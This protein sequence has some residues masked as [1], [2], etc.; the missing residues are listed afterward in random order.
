MPETESVASLPA[1]LQLS[2]DEQAF[3][4]CEAALV[5]DGDQ[6]IVGANAAA[7]H[8]LRHP[9]GT[10]TGRALSTLL[11][12][13]ARVRHAAQVRRFADAGTGERR[14]VDRGAVTGLR[15]DG[16]ECE[17]EVYLWRLDLPAGGAAAPMCLALLRD[18]SI[19]P[20]LR[21][22]VSDLNQRFVDVLDMAPVA[23]W[24]AENDRVVFANRAAHALFEA[25]GGRRIVG[26]P[27]R[28]LI[29]SDAWAALQAQMERALAGDDGGPP[30]Q[31]R[32]TRADGSTR[33]V[34]IGSAPLPD[35]GRT[36]V[37]MV[38][39]DITAHRQQAHAEAAHRAELR[40]LSANVVEARE[41]ERR[42][43]AREL[44]DE[45]GQRLSGLK[46]ALSTP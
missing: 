7:E 4:A 22:Q 13:R 27:V 42:R 25:P 39:S 20:T 38:I 33:E 31:G 14:M 8:L 46:M 5:V 10:L 18:A 40:H 34:E 45:L 23:M 15:G 1:L 17:I 19:A 28:E 16:S 41:E 32:I 9:V 6:T 43:I 37:Q 29:S 30:V 21:R 24:V 26:A 35:H 11:P 44:H 12:E 36:V 3:A 2:L